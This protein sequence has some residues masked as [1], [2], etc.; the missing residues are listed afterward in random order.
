MQVY[1]LRGTPSLVIIDRQGFI[2][3]DH[4]GSFDDLQIGVLLGR[5]VSESAN[6]T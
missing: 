6:Q 1:G 2:R 5:L 3:L 4:F